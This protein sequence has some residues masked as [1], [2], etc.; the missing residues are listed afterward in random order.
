MFGANWQQVIVWVLDRVVEVIDTHPDKFIHTPNWQVNMPS[1]VRFL[2]PI[3]RKKA[4]KFSRTNVYLRDKGRCQYCGA[5]VARDEYQY[6]HV[7]PRCQGG[8]TNFENIVT[9]CHR[10]NQMKAGRSPQQAE[11]RLL[12]VPVKPKKLPDFQYGHTLTYK[13]GMPDAWRQ[14]LRDAIYWGGELEHD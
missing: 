7:I 1:V 14:Y 13:S 9:C 5:R 11:M 2:K 12:S 8:I 6:D 4:V 10:C 3:P